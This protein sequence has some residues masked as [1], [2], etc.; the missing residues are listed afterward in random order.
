MYLYDTKLQLSGCDFTSN[1]ASTAGGAL[2]GED[3]AVSLTDSTASANIATQGGGFAIMKVHSACGD[4]CE[5]G[6]KRG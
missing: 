3:A 6:G 2:A 4:E 5:Q 1:V